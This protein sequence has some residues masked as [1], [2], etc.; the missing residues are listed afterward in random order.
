MA[1][2]VWDAWLSLSLRLWE[3][4]SALQQQQQQQAPRSL[5]EQLVALVLPPEEPEPELPE[6]CPPALLLG[7]RAQFVVLMLL[8]NSA[9]LNQLVQSMGRFGTTRAATLINSASFCLSG[10]LGGLV[11]GEP[12]PPL[13]W[14]G[15]V[16][17]VAGVFLVLSGQQ[18]QEQRQQRQQAQPQPQQGQQAKKER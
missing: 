3:G 11:F 5:F 7:V 15:V 4:E 16:V 9:M 18:R 17:I 13:W 12:T 6:P 8:L 10:L 2:A 14:L 1:D